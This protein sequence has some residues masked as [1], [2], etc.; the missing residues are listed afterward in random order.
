MPLLPSAP[1]ATGSTT[2]PPTARFG[3]GD[4]VGTGVAEA[5]STTPV[6][7]GLGVGGAVGVGDVSELMIVQA[8]VWFTIAALQMPFV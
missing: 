1:P 4:G 8:A 2:A 5:G 6:G 7:E 3:V